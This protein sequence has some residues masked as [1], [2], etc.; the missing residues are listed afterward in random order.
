MKKGLLLIVALAIVGA[1][2][3]FLTGNPLGHLVKV[4]IEQFGP[5]MTQA[6]VSVGAVVISATDGEGSISGL[7]IGNPQGFKTDYALKADRIALSIEPSSLT[8]DVILIRKI[9]LDGPSII[10]EKNDK[11]IANFDA[12]Q[13]NVEQYLG[14]SGKNKGGDE[15]SGEQK[16]MIIDSL[17]IRNAK[18]SYS[19]LM[20][21]SDIDLPT[22]E[23]HDIGKKTGGVDSSGLARAIVAE[24]NAQIIKAATKAAADKVGAAADKAKDAFKGLLG[25]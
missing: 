9:E 11:G 16:K 12:I 6:E 20:D 17:V 25:K 18:V 22:I 4:A 10:Y 21:I 24:L 8:K 13:R 14:V 2:V 23:L 5:K 7:K 19:G 15:K 3:F 1:V